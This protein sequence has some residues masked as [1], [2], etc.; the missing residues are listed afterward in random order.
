MSSFFSS[1]PAY[2]FIALTYLYL[3]SFWTRVS[4]REIFS[5]LLSLSFLFPGLGGDAPAALVSDSLLICAPRLAPSQDPLRFGTSTP[6]K[7]VD[8]FDLLRDWFIFP[9]QYEAGVEI[10]MSIDCRRCRKTLHLVRRGSI[11]FQCGGAR[12]GSRLADCEIRTRRSTP[13][14]PDLLLL[15][16]YVPLQSVYGIVY[17]KSL[18]VPP[19]TP[20]SGF[21]SSLVQW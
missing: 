15:Y 17:N 13:K 1:Y 12:E 9:L 21:V 6:H 20:Q 3:R 4:F 14:A 11:T 2:P 8:C 7:A 10:V 16:L 19:Q 5:F 18:A